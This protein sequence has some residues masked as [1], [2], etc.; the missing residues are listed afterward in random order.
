M[1][2]T[3]FILLFALLLVI[4]GTVVASADGTC[5]S[6]LQW[7]YDSTS[8]T[9]TI[10]GS[11]AM[12][13]YSS[14]TTSG[15]TAPWQSQYHTQIQKVVIETGVTSIGKCAFTNCTNLTSLTIGSSVTTINDS[16]FYGCSSLYSVSIPNSVKSINYCAFYNC[17]KMAYLT[18]GTGV[19]TIGTSAFSGCS[20]LT[21]VV[22]PSSVTSIGQNAFTN[23]NS[24]ISL[25]LPYLPQGFMG[26]IFGNNASSASY[27]STQNSK[28]PSSLKSVI[29]SG[30]TTLSIGAFAYC[31]GL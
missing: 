9:V 18:I 10:S 14:S 1:K 12:Y 21:G 26:Y 11:G 4:A 23:C 28:V 3:L 19:T 16:A 22:V 29:L 25:T 7:S 20:K 2:K 13:D 8:K 31:K 6:S 24:L 27:Y 15:S 17:S 30:G 5:G